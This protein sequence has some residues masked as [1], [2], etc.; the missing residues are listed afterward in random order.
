MKMD[1]IARER[2]GSFL[3]SPVWDTT[4]TEAA[5]RATIGLDRAR[6]AIIAT[7]REGDGECHIEPMV[8]KP[9]APQARDTRCLAR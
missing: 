2:S 7:E 4:L 1:E 6:H 8:W 5:S 9:G 3:H